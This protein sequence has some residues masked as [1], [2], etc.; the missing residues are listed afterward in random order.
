MKKFFLFFRKICR[1]LAGCYYKM[2]GMDIDKTAVISLKARLDF[3]Y[4][5]GIHI[6]SHTSITGGSVILTHDH[7]RKIHTDTWIGNHCVIGINSIVLPGVHIGNHC[8]VGAGSVVTKDVPSHTIVAGNPARIIREGIE[9][10]DR[11]I[12]INK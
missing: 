3:T 10:S 1:L 8:V 7:C 4:P 2:L 5:K 11:R 12:I 9:L 6:G